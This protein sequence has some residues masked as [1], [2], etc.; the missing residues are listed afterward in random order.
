M[1]N[2]HTWDV[3][4][5]RGRPLARL[6]LSEGIAGIGTWEFDDLNGCN[7][8]SPG[9]FAI[10]GL[11]PSAFDLTSESAVGILPPEDHA[12]VRSLVSSVLD[13]EAPEP[14]E[15]RVVRP[16]GEVRWCESRCCL[17]RPGVVVGVFLDITR[18]RAAQ[19]HQFEQAAALHEAARAKTDFLSRMN[20]ELRTPLHS[21][22]GYSQLL[23][24]SYLEPADRESIAHIRTAG[25]HLLALINDILDLTSVESGPLAFIFEQFDVVE[26]VSEALKLIQPMAS[27]SG[28]TL[29]GPIESRTGQ[30]L[31]AFA[32]RRRVLQIL[33]NLLSN[34]VKYNC[35]DGIVTVAVD[36]TNEGVAI[37]VSDTGVGID[38]VDIDRVFEPFDRL[39]ADQRDIEGT[40]IGLA[41]ARSL[42]VMMDG[43]LTLESAVGTGS[44][45]T[46]S[47]P[48]V[49][50]A[51]TP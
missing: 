41:L 8:W 14:M 50:A 34:S 7:R 30:T 33:L 15:L 3:N 31:Q 10:A 21:I 6:E 16:T 40:G 13:G 19:L 42:A 18:R 29:S 11:D 27:A 28:I 9:L 36:G 22:L 43:S 1:G 25:D 45:F 48:P 49:V 17:V 35:E 32:D 24:L 44:T 39:G 5:T 20:H 23:D 51:S 47:L 4:Q 12:T 26:V 2:A 38:A 37:A 46:L